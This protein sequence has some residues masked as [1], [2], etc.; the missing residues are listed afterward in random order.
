MK[1]FILAW[2][3][4]NA[5]DEEKAKEI[6]YRCERF[7]IRYAEWYSEVK[8]DKYNYQIKGDNLIKTFKEQKNE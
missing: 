4:A 5:T 3:S 1:E 2:L 8:N 6:E 7:A